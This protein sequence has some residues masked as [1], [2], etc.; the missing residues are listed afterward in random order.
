MLYLRLSNKAFV[1]REPGKHAYWQA[2]EFP[3]CGVCGVCGQR[4]FSLLFTIRQS[5]FRM[6]SVH[7]IISWLYRLWICTIYFHFY[8]LEIFQ[9]T[10]QYTPN[11]LQI[12]CRSHAIQNWM[13]NNLYMSLP[14]MSQRVFL[15][16]TLVYCKSGHF[17]NGEISRN[18][19]YLPI[20]EFMRKEKQNKMYLWSTIAPHNVERSVSQGQGHKRSSLMSSESVSPKEHV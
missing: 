19:L 6:N 14:K 12:R 8:K 2:V 13:I 7:V 10:K 20:R 5:S 9:R 18:W 3:F 16:E 11:T 4:W 1:P 15:N 17:R